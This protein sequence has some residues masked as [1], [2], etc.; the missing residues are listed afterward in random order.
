VISPQASAKG[1]PAGPLEEVNHKRKPTCQFMRHL[2]VQRQINASC[3]QTPHH[4]EGRTS[5]YLPFMVDHE[6]Y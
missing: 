1:I 6:I 2:G 4:T 5:V 3:G